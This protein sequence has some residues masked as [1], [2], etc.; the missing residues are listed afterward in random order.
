MGEHALIVKMVRH[1]AMENTLHVF[2]FYVNS[3]N[4]ITTYLPIASE[5]GVIKTYIHLLVSL[6]TLSITILSTSNGIL[7]RGQ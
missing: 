6:S 5:Q 3:C 7:T 4:M 1:N 2:D